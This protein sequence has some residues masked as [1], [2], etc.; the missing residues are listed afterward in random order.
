MHGFVEQGRR[1]RCRASQATAKRARRGA[2]TMRARRLQ[3]T[4]VLSADPA[5]AEKHRAVRF[6]R[7][8][9][10]HRVGRLAFWLLLGNAK[11]NSLARRASE[12]SDSLNRRALEEHGAGFQLYSRHT[13]ARPSGQLRCSRALCARS[14]WNDEQTNRI[15]LDSGLRR[16]DE[17]ESS[18]RVPGASVAR[19]RA[20]SSADRLSAKPLSKCVR[21]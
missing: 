17:Q 21:T 18:Q 8:E 14:R 7:C 5:G 15:T 4:D 9:S 6:A 12:S 3:Y 2:R 13:G 16:N 19:N 10:N 11:S 1:S 20:T